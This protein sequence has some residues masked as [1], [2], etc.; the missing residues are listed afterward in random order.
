VTGTA[1]AVALGLSHVSCKVIRGSEGLSAA[2][3]CKKSC[4]VKYKELIT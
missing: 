1:A 2:S 4:V 3:Q